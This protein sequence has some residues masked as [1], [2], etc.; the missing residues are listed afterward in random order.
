M[1]I[2]RKLQKKARQGYDLAFQAETQAQGHISFAKDDRYWVSGDGFHSVIDVIEFPTSG[3]VD[4]WGMDIM[5]ID[6]TTA[7][8][9]VVHQ[10]SSDVQSRS[11]SAVEEKNSRI[12]GNSKMS[13]NRKEISEIQVL[14]QME[15]DLRN[16]L[17]G[18]KGIWVRIKVA[19]NTEEE[20]FRL[21]KDVKD[22]APRYKMAVFI[23]EQELEFKAPFVPPER[24]EDLPN[25]RKPHILTTNALAGMYFFNHTKLEDKHGSYIG[26]TTTDGAVN[27]N[28]LEH[29]EIRN[30]P[31]M[32]IAGSPNMNQ[33]KFLLKHS[34]QL[35]AKGH[36]QFHID[37]DGTF[38]TLSKYQY[39][40]IIDFSENGTNRI[41]LFQIFPIV[42]NSQG[43]VDEKGCYY[44]KIKTLK[45]IATILNKEINNDDLQVMNN[46][47]NDF[48]I[49]NELWRENVE[50]DII[51]YVT[52]F[53][54]EEYPK[55]SD[56]ILFLE[57]YIRIK[58]HKGQKEVVKSARKIHTAFNN[59][60][61]TYKDVF[62]CYTEFEDLSDEQVITFSLRTLK[63][64]PMI[65][66][67]QFTQILSLILSY[68]IRNGIEQ[69][70]LALRSNLSKDQMTHC[71]LNISSAD[72]VL[73]PF[74]PENVSLLADLLDELTRNYGGAVLE[75]GSLQSML[76][77]G[78]S[79]DLD[80]YVISIRR[81]FD[82][83]QYKVLAN[84]DENTVPLLANIVGSSIT[85]SQLETLPRLI[86]GQF[87]MNI[88]N[89]KN[90]IFNLELLDTKI[91]ENER[92]AGVD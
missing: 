69:K 86:Q 21:V 67:V 83:I 70:R 1:S 24:L 54:N 45:T 37:I 61:S 12:S 79:N 2:K 33:K 27:F 44:Q 82:L 41:N 19:A 76:L 6:N 64:D 77:G 10:N 68:V 48:Y 91:N 72:K 59:L 53:S 73:E 34:D 56:F 85:K 51:P 62:D 7:F 43:E 14:E 65:L 18:A 35:Y 92:Y 52:R 39:A 26:F 4:N 30:K 49:D 60:Y 15:A 55:L 84:I 75:L 63:N 58:E 89:D 87:L 90:F 88:S 17:T 38:E 16:G 31:I 71:I 29:D 28:L 11:A 81:I 40:K 32:L 5:Q 80:P 22:A 42:V 9:Q 46:V 66:N 13:T 8:L 47:L 23:G 57:Q 74:Y 78:N 25:G 36:K 3:L 50:D 20:L